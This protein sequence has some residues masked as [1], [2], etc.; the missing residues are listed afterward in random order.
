MENLVSQ[1]S[2]TKTIHDRKMIRDEVDV[3]QVVFMIVDVRMMVY[4][5]EVEAIE[6]I[7]GDRFQ[8]LEA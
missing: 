5:V 4:D 7:L 2:H 3:K 8:I 1:V 6:V